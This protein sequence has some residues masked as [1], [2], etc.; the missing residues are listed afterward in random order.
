MMTRKENFQIKKKEELLVPF[1]PSLA[2]MN[3]IKGRGSFKVSYENF[4]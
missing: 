2:K 3:I 4:E 1:R